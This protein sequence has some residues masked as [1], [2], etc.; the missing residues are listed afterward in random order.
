MPSYTRREWLNLTAAAAVGAHSFRLGRTG[1]DDL[2]AWI[3]GVMRARKLPGLSAAIVKKGS[4]VWS[5]GY[6]W[7]NIAR[8]TP[9]NPDRSLQNI[10]SVSKTVTATA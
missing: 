6:G 10:A 2:D 8:R 1:S 5:H 3:E 7:A 9:M 4:V